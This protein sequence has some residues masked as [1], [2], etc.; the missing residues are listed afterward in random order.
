MAP[1]TDGTLLRSWPSGW[2]RQLARKTIRQQMPASRCSRMA[3]PV[4]N[5]AG[6][7]ALMDRHRDGEIA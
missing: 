7:G 2:P 3:M 5:Q 1:I 6:G 4:P